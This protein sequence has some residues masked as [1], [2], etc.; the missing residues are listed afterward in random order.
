MI[1]INPLSIMMICGKC[2]C[3][4]PDNS[5]FCTRCGAKV[6]KEALIPNLSIG[7]RFDLPDEQAITNLIEILN[8]KLARAGNKT[9]IISALTT[10]ERKGAGIPQLVSV[11]R[12][13][14]DIS[15]RDAETLMRTWSGQ[16]HNKAAWQRA[17]EYA[18]YKEWIGTPGSPRTRESHLK[19]NG[20]II[21]VD[22]YFIVP[23]FV[24]RYTHE[25]VPEALMMYPGD[26]SQGPHQ[27]QICRCRCA[28]APRFLRKGK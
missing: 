17:K 4:I 25:K 23:G 19:M 11:Y 26:V 10:A 24:D 15:E 3:Q 14:V 5:N 27:S 22:E 28:L 1:G 7:V 12:N 8:L 18:P 16:A 20:V 6:D 9:E 21:P 2:K 13:F